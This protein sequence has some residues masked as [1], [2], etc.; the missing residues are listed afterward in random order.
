MAKC[1]QLTSLPFKGL[2][3]FYLVQGGCV[4]AL[5]CLFVGMFVYLYVCLITQKVVE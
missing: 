3:D 1:N 5:V 4:F 2:S